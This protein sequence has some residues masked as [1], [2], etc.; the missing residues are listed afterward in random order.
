MTEAI[1]Y[2]P[3][4]QTEWWNEHC[5]YAKFN[6]QGVDI[7]TASFTN[8]VAKAAVIVLTGWSET[9]LKYADLIRALYDHGFS[10]FT[11]DHQS[12]GLSGRWLAETQSTWIHSFEDYVD[13][14]VY[15][16]TLITRETPHLPVYLFA[17]SMGGLVA[18]IAMSR[19]PSLIRRAVLRYTHV[20]II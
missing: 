3:V 19:L 8:P 2:T 15:Y 17:H 4:T 9:F 12:Q 14:F 5:E 13:D 20:A 11:Y 10:V 18:S 7:M 6:R 1:R 16:V